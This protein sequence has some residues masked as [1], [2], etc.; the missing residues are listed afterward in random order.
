MLWSLLNRHWQPIYCQ[1]SL[2]F[3]KI[4]SGSSWK[5]L[6]RCQGF[7]IKL[8]IH[9]AN[10][11]HKTVFGNQTTKYREARMGEIRKNHLW[12]ECRSNVEE[13]VRLMV[14]NVNSN[15]SINY[16]YDVVLP[17][18]STAKGWDL[19]SLASYLMP[20]CVFFPIYLL[21]YM[22]VFKISAL[23]IMLLVRNLPHPLLYSLFLDH[24]L[25]LKG[26]HRWNHK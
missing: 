24:S 16:L 13:K 23:M 5:Y 20:R 6:K 7:L 4:V 17:Y 14:C 3:F 8:W 19:S 21:I 12:V 18:W 15:K 1:V 22:F 26:N 2:F 9:N 25:T 10:A 11:K